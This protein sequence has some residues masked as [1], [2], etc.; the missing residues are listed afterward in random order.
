[1]VHYMEYE[2][3]P[4]Y[5]PIRLDTTYPNFAVAKYVFIHIDIYRCMYI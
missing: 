1:M 2:S 5:L 3:Y 4:L